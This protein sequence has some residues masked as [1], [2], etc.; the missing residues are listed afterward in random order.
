M[1]M[2]HFGK[3]EFGDGEEITYS[4]STKTIMRMFI[5]KVFVAHVSFLA[6]WFAGAK[7]RYT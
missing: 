2:D 7:E 1:G 4:P 5:S 6:T 3:Y